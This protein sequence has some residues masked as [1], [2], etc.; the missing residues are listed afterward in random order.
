MKTKLLLIMG[1]TMSIFHQLRF[2]AVIAGICFGLWPLFINRSGLTGNMA[3]LTASA[4]VL[5]AISVFV[6]KELW[7]DNQ[8][9][10]ILCL[11]ILFITFPFVVKWIGTFYGANFVMPFLLG[12]SQ[13][14]VYYFLIVC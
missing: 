13:Q 12:F 3:S 10:V 6:I 9:S 2:L 14:P 7:I 5:M 1:G 8:I 4:V 11:L